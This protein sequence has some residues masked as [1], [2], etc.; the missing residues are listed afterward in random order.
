MTEIVLFAPT[1]GREFGERVSQALG[2]PLAA[3]EE[4]EFEDGEHKVRPL[5]NVR[6]RDVFLVQSLYGDERQSVND[7]LCRML[8]FIGALHDASAGRITA[9]VPYLCYSRKD[10]KS[11]T[12]DPVTTRYVA[13]LFESVGTGHVVTLDVH[14]LAAFQNAWRIPADHLEAKRIFIDHLA[15]MVQREMP[16]VVSPDSGGVKRAE[17]FRVALS[18]RLQRE[19]PNAFLEKHR[20][21]G[22]V[23]G[24]A[25]VG[26][27]DGKT[28]IIVDDLISSG[29]TIARAA[30]TCLRRDAARVI[31]VATHGL[32]ST[33]A[34]VVLA[35]P[36]ISRIVITNSVP[37][38]RLDTKLAEQKVTVLDIAPLVA[39]AI[40]RIQAGGSLVDLMAFGPPPASSEV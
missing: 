38:F 4:R 36:A 6:G 22:V 27:V 39:E 13:A 26:P 11:K 32:F 9:V 24:E 10:R 25:L 29:T 35:N 8:F 40:R 31:A 21:S 5:E 14:N 37:P 15:P 12:R 20:S 28:A 7:K 17:E 3:H 19:V 34:S 2:V 1:A 16:V 33:Q 23:T 30:E 18:Q